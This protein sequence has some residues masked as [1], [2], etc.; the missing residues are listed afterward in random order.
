MPW[1]FPD[2]FD[3]YDWQGPR[4]RSHRRR[5]DAFQQLVGQAAQEIHGL[6]AHVASTTGRDGSIDIYVDDY[7]GNKPTFQGWPLPLILEC[8]DH[9]EGGRDL[10]KNI[11]AGWRTVREKLARQ[12][13]AGWSGTFAP[14]SGARTYLYCLSTHLPSQSARDDLQNEKP[15]ATRSGSC[16][17]LV[18]PARLARQLAADRRCLAGDSHEPSFAENLTSS[19]RDWLRSMEAELAS[20]LAA[21]DPDEAGYALG[22]VIAG[23]PWDEPA[24]E[25]WDA[26]LGPWLD[27]RKGERAARHLLYRILFDATPTAVSSVGK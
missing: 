10:M 4:A 2:R 24:L 20:I 21:A 22:S 12:A 8:K 23:P 5:E 27:R 26:L 11:Q 9:D 1:S 15:A 7:P 14:W 13:E 17:R 6:R 25:R 19:A 18:G 16:A 3:P